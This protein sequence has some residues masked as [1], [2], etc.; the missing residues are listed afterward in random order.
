MHMYFSIQ[1]TAIST[2]KPVSAI[3]C[4]VQ[5]AVQFVS[6]VSYCQL[7]IGNKHDYSFQETAI[8]TIKPVSAIP[9]SVQFSLFQQSPIVN[10]KEATNMIIPFKKLQSVNLS[11]NITASF[12]G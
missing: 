7:L 9:C 8:S 2:I 11:F 1:G 12:E 3:P 6:I 4:S 5:C 10:C